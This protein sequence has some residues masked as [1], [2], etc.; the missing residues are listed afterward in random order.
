MTKKHK[1]AQTIE[2]LDSMRLREEGEP[3]ELAQNTLPLTVT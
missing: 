3:E 1:A 2:D